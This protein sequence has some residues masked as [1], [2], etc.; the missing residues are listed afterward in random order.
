MSGAPEKRFRSRDEH[1]AIAWITALSFEYAAAIHLLEEEYEEDP[2]EPYT[3][4][5]ITY[6]NVVIA[7]LPA[8][9]IGTCSAATVTT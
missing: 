3:F 9:R 2:Q 4:G 5:R 1:F 7:C 8:G 6:H